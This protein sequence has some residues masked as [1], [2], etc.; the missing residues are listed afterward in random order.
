VHLGIGASAAALHQVGRGLAGQPR[1]AAMWGGAFGA[2]FWALNYVFVAP[3][4]GIMPPP[5]RDRPGRAPIMLG[6]NIVWG[7]VSAVLGDR[8]ARIPASSRASCQ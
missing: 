7:V 6:A 1:P 4:L 5:D 2:L 8:L 3:V